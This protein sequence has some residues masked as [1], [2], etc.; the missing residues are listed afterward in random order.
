MVVR[1]WL[2]AHF[3][4]HVVL[5]LF[6]CLLIRAHSKVRKWVG[7][8][9]S[10]HCLVVRSVRLAPL[11][12]ADAIRVGSGPFC[13]QRGG[14]SAPSPSRSESE[15]HAH[16]RCTTI[17]TPMSTHPL[18]N[19]LIPHICAK[20]LRCHH[21][22]WH[23]ISN[24]LQPLHVLHRGEQNRGIWISRRSGRRSTP[25]DRPSWTWTWRQRRECMRM[26]WNALAV[27]TRQLRQ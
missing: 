2:D 13:D 15:V 10:V 23:S 25:L 1:A 3:S 4:V 18:W 9:T 27:A 24:Q 17:T 12:H 8:A 14:Q 11:W 22:K 21:E 16:A 7:D 6:S 5:A 26:M 20:P 19:G